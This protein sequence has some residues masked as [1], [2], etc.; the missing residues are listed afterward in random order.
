[1]DFK[2]WRRFLLNPDSS[3]GRLM[4][5]IL[6]ASSRCFPWFGLDIY[7]LSKRMVTCL[8]ERVVEVLTHQTYPIVILID[9]SGRGLLI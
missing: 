4:P 5:G 3:R 7:C 2:G 9:L 1:M 6:R 8:A